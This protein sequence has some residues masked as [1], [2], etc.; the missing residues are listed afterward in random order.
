MAS[1]LPSHS[2]LLRHW[3]SV[4]GADLL[5]PRPKAG[6]AGAAA[7][8]PSSQPTTAPAQTPAP[9]P[10]PAPS[11][12]SA[13]PPSPPPTAT[14]NPKLPLHLQDLPSEPGA[15]LSRLA[16]LSRD[17]AHC[18]LHEK[19]QQAVF[20]DG[21]LGAEIMFVGEAPGAQ[22]D[23]QGVPF[24]GAAG[25]LLTRIIENA[26]GIPR[27]AVYIANVVKCR[28]PGNRN[29]SPEEQQRC[30]PYLEEQI[31][32]LRPKILICLGAI[33]AQYLLDTKQGAGRL[34]G[35]VHQWEKIPLVVTWHPAYLLRTPSAKRETW[36]D[37]QLALRT[38]GR[39]E[40]PKPYKADA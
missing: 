40:R 9:A 30:G 35:R 20:G 28:P 18:G 17:C 26:M 23:A 7:A 3:L 10:V 13:K 32:A 37:I 34:R 25:Q 14:P 31:R 6:A 27:S 33:A 4:A 2:T 16:E 38:L 8:A 24:V 12:A 22:E 15:R 1:R 5:L 11:P 29:P 36:S 19:R 21:E 39:P